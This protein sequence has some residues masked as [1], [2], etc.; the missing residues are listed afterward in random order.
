M[1]TITF[2]IIG[3]L[4]FWQYLCNNPDQ[5]IIIKIDTVETTIYRDSL[6]PDTTIYQKNDF[7][8]SL[9]KEI[10]HLKY[11]INNFKNKSSDTINIGINKDTLWW[12]DTVIFIIDKYYAKNCYRD[13]LK[14]DST[15][16]ILISDTIS[17][18]KILARTAD[19]RIYNK[20]KIIQDNNKRFYIGAGTAF[21][22]ENVVFNGNFY[23]QKNKNIYGIGIN[24]NKQ[25]LFNYIYQIK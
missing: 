24:S 17:Q 21:S 1:K 16:F 10:N 6:V 23:Y 18:N 22:F 20:T 9:K 2:L 7:I 4:F 19:I 13:T 3:I 14:D 11:I 12:A 5:E 8:K 25:I 15:A